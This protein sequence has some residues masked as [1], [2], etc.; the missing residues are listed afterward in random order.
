MKTTV[1]LPDELARRVKAEAAMRGQ[2]L[3]DL[4]EEGMRNE[5]ETPR[6]PGSGI[7]RPSLHDLMKGACGVVDSGVADLAS[8]PKHLKGFGS[9]PRRHR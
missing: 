9:A 8:N 6:K 5:L 4:C 7:P 2:K 3:K 1:E